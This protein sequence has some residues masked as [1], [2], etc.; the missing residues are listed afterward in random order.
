M[1]SIKAFRPG[2]SRKRNAR[3][4]QSERSYSVYPGQTI[5]SFGTGGRSQQIEGLLQLSEATL[6]TIFAK[7]SAEQNTEI[8]LHSAK[9]HAIEHFLGNGPYT[10]SEPTTFWCYLLVAGVG[11]SRTDPYLGVDHPNLEDLCEH[12]WSADDL[13]ILRLTDLFSLSP[14]SRAGHYEA[15][16]VPEMFQKVDFDITAEIQKRIRLLE[17]SGSYGTTDYPDIMFCRAVWTVTNGTYAHFLNSNWAFEFEYSEKQKTI[18][19]LL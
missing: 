4:T 8:L 9:F 18:K 2:K 19:S 1:S 13:E 3:R 17:A 7:E 5:S 16:Q 11:G 14:N 15:S 6:E 12:Y 10:A